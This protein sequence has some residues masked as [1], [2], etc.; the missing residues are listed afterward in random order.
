VWPGWQP[1]TCLPDACFCEGIRQ[2]A[3]AQP[4]NFWSSFAFV[5]VGLFVWRSGLFAATL[6]LVGA[7]S[8]FYHASLTFTGQAA[9]VAGMYGIATAAI[10]YGVRRTRRVPAV[11]FV[12]ANV[13]LIATQ[14]L[15]PEARRFVFAGLLAGV[16]VTQRWSGW[17]ARALVVFAIGAAFWAVDLAR[18]VCAPESLVQGHA[19]WHVAGATAAWL[20]YR[21]F[22][23]TNQIKSAYTASHGPG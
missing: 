10:L 22:G 5:V 9:D 21:H 1:A 20:L 16:L 12:A 4:A 8:A 7:G 17:M 14:V 13:L 3:I 2:G 19:V 11:W 18:V 6:V 23:L 15:F